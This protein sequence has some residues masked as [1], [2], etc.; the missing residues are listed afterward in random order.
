MRF[1]ADQ[2]ITDNE[3]ESAI[4]RAEAFMAKIGEDLESL[5]DLAHESTFGEVIELCFARP[6]KKFRWPAIV[7]ASC[8]R[9]NHT[10]GLI[11]NERVFIMGR[12]LRVHV[13]RSIGMSLVASIHSSAAKKWETVP[14]QKSAWDLPQYDDNTHVRQQ[15]WYDYLDGY[16]EG[17]AMSIH[18]RVQSTVEAGIPI[19]SGQPGLIARTREDADMEEAEAYAYQNHMFMQDQMKSKRDLN[20]DSYQSGR[21]AGSN[22]D[23]TAPQKRPG[24][25][26]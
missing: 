20:R 23:I 6:Y 5:D 9:L 16:G 18:E 22:I 1:A 19:D 4:R 2:S 10:V 13:A 8:A 12:E 17:A 25:L 24:K 11:S 3:R 7:I 14:V 26:T 15:Q 21:T